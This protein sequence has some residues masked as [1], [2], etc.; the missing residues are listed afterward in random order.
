MASNEP[1]V[2]EML[3]ILHKGFEDQV[4]VHEVVVLDCQVR[5]RGDGEDTSG[6]DG[7]AAEGDI[8]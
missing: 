8:Q 6:Q 2:T 4:V 3:T 7:S 5:R 1:V